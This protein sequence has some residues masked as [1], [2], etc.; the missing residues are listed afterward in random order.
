M[1]IINGNIYKGDWSVNPGDKLI[2]SDKE[3]SISIADNVSSID[4]LTEEKSKLMSATAGAALG[5]LFA[6]PIGTAVGAGIGAG[7]KNEISAIITLT[8]GESFTAN[9]STTEYKIFKAEQ[10]STALISKTKD[11]SYTDIDVDTKECPECAEIIKSKAKI[12]RYCRYKFEDDSYQ[13][14]E[15]DKNNSTVKFTDEEKMDIYNTIRKALSKRKRDRLL[16]ETANKYNTT[17][18]RIRGTYLTESAKHSK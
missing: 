15:S 2:I 7:G 4:K 13:E 17:V 5:F 16:E 11:N 12:C 3:R 9:M 14:K 8:S 18:N 6:G 10:A 1:K